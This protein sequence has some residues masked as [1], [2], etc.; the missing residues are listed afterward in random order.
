MHAAQGPYLLLTRTGEPVPTL[1]PRPTATAPGTP[2]LALQGW[3]PECR[4]PASNGAGITAKS[5]SA[6]LGYP[7]QSLRP[8]STPKLRSLV[9]KGNATNCR[10]HEHSTTGPEPAEAAIPA[11]CL[12]RGLPGSAGS[13]LRWALQGLPPPAGPVLPQRPRPYLQHAFI[14]LGADVHS[15]DS[16]GRRLHPTL[17]RLHL[18]GGH[19]RFERRLLRELGRGRETSPLCRRPV[20]TWVRA[21]A[22]QPP[23][24]ELTGPRL[25]PPASPSARRPQHSR[26][27]EAQ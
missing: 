24:C 27:P 4:P 21:P 8:P 18:L 16:E 19:G 3:G 23:T 2:Q 9:Q 15:L 11:P 20:C 13:R 1:L 25:G 14:L 10:L 26:A 22:L 17:G 7:L 12:G 6:Y 5:R